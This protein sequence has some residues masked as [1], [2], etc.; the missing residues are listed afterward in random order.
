MEFPSRC[1]FFLLLLL[2]HA[3]GNAECCCCCPA[4]CSSHDDDDD[5]EDDGRST[6]SHDSQCFRFGCLAFVYI[7]SLL[8]VYIFNVVSAFKAVVVVVVGGGELRRGRM[9]VNVH[10]ESILPLPALSLLLPV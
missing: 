3:E 5:E 7:H 4:A 1:A 9:R 6:P 2:R 8:V 10:I